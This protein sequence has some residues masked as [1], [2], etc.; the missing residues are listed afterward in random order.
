MIVAAVGYLMETFGD[1]L[2]PGNEVWLAWVVGLSAALGEVE[3]ALYMVIKGTKTSYS[4]K[5]KT[6][7]L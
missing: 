4:N 5:L 3:L 7:Q 2:F 6:Q 1:L